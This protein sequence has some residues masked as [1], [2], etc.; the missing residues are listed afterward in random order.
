MKKSYI[1]IV[2]FLVYQFSSNANYAAFGTTGKTKLSGIVSDKK[3]GEKIAGASIYFPDLQTGT[4]SDTNGSYTINN[5]PKSKALLQ[6]SFIGYRT[7]IETIDL[8]TVTIKNFEM[9]TAATEMN[10]VVITGL[11]KAAEQKRTATPIAVIPRLA[12]LQSSSSNIIDA[13]STQPGVSQVTTGT[14]ISKPVI[15]GLGYNRVVVVNDGI[16]QEGQQWGDE[17]GIEIDEFSVN[18]VEILKGP[19]SLAFGSDAMAGVVNMISAP[20]LTEGK[21][22]GN[23][24]TN[25]KTNNGLIGYSADFAGNKKGFVW[26]MRYSNK[27]AHSYQNK[28]DGYVSNSGFR[29]NAISGL[30]GLNKSWGY[31]HLILSAYNF[32][33]G[34]VEGIRDSITGKFVKPADIN[35]SE[36]NE[37]ATDKDFKS[38]TPLT[39]YQQIHHYKAVINSSFI[40]GKGSLKTIIGFQQNHRQEYA[41]ILKP[42]SY[43]LYFLLNT[44]NY[45]VRYNLPEKKHFDVSFG[46]N[47]M[48]QVSQNKGT[49][50]LI[51]DYNMF[52][53]GVFS[54]LKKSIGKFDLSGGLRYDSRS[55]HGKDLY[56]NSDGSATEVPNDESIHRFTD[57]KTTFT[58]ISGSI[59]ATWQI[60]KILFTK[61]N[62][63]RGY[64]APNIGELASN[65]VHEGT[66]RYEIGDPELKAE[67]SLQYD[68]ALG[69][70]TEHISAELDVFDNTIDNYIFSRKLNNNSGGDSITDGYSTFKFVAGNAHLYGGEFRVDIHP[71]PYDWIHFE[72]A[73]SF[74]NAIQKNQPDSSKYLPFTPAPKFMTGIKVD[75]NVFKKLLRNT[76]AKF[77]MENYFAQ[78][79]FYAAYGTETRTPGYIILNLGLGTDFANKGKTIC[80]FY[81]SANNLGNVAYQSHLSRLK[82][83]PENYATG[84]TGVYNMG[85]NISFK[86]I[87]PINIE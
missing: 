14:G 4:T 8:D 75:V 62:I 78:N 72:N 2:I 19:A 23:I 50:Y 37:I 36:G 10:E 77:D 24:A 68:Y 32:T 7:I 76:Y 65:G 46:V 29:E 45:D 73:F 71:H 21:I 18:K 41:D 74:V 58:G 84:R 28:Y 61:L 66:M 53:I 83:D 49:E 30:I 82:Y 51:P 85:R 59:G 48:K 40:V 5:L 67:S 55:E 44:L 56:L 57:F 80:S 34:I 9:E 87:V 47:G 60:S 63:S 26:D 52:D 1:I 64:R 6:V 13:L 15:R 54:I 11:S 33:P 12:L 25:Y 27:L 39:P 22:A 17:H 86:V 43:G 81:L 70:S 31:S 79:K 16:R 20:T 3:T 38:Y 69:L 35:G 42:D